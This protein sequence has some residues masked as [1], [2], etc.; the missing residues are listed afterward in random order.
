MPLFFQRYQQKKYTG[1]LSFL[2][3]IW[4]WFTST[5]SEGT[6]RKNQVNSVI[7]KKVDF[8]S[9]TY[10]S[11]DDPEGYGKLLGYHKFHVKWYH[12]ETITKLLHIILEDDNEDISAENPEESEV[13]TSI[14]YQC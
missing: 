3:K 14:L 9:D 13:T 11:N 1:R 8:I 4:W 10:P 6:E 5:L 7:C 12:G 2:K